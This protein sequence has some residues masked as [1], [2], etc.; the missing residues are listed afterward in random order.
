MK[1]R[2]WFRLALKAIGVLLIGW[3]LSSVFLFIGM[4]YGLVTGSAGLENYAPSGSNT[5]FESA[6]WF[7]LRV[8]QFL[9]SAMVGVYL[10]FGGKWLL[11]TIIPPD[12]PYCMECGYD[13]S[14]THGAY[15]P[16]CGE[17]CEREPAAGEAGAS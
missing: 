5:V 13:L 6:V 1:H 17:P 14:H 9:S 10:V 8:V 16:E 11:N 3:S 2:A 4:V 7:A 12:R 15:C